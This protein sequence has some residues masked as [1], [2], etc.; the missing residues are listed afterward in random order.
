MR[1]LVPAIFF[2]ALTSV[3]GAA[4]ALRPLCPNRPGDATP[5]CIVD[6]GHI[7]VETGL[8]DWSSDRRSAVDRDIVSLFSTEIRY[9]L[10]GTTEIGVIW[11]PYNSMTIRD[12]RTHDRAHSAGVGDLTLSVR[13][14]IANPDGAGVALA[15]QPFI[16]APT[17]TNGMGAGGWSFGVLVP[18]SV[19][20]GSGFNLG[21]SAQIKSVPSDSGGRHAAYFGVVGASHQIGPLQAGVEFAAASEQS[22]TQAT[23]NLTL[24][25]TPAKRPNFQIDAG[26]NRGLNPNTPSTRIYFGVSQLF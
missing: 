22:V 16:I 3:P 14:S 11:S 18:F 13:R 26:L 21:T 5:A 8:A 25:W 1:C 19:D 6:A 2:F 7:Q 24:A 23:A 15:I 10:D 9:G 4:E 17:G 20:I 12:V